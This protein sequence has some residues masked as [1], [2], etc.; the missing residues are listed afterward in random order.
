MTSKPSATIVSTKP[1]AAEQE[2]SHCAALL[3]VSACTG[4]PPR[5]TA[6][7]PAASHRDNEWLARCLPRPARKRARQQAHD[8]A[9]HASPCARRK[10]RLI[11]HEARLQRQ[12]RIKRPQCDVYSGSDR[13]TQ[14]VQY[15]S[16]ELDGTQVPW[17]RAASG[18][19]LPRL[20]QQQLPTRPQDRQDRRRSAPARNQKIRRRGK[21]HSKISARTWPER[22][23]APA[24]LLR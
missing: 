4:L 13:L 12:P 24:L 19:D 22:L 21:S 23:R 9:E 16:G 2:A 18:A 15:E 6:R 20:P 1:A 17:L 14:K 5:P 8:G 11:D 10:L 7:P 3:R